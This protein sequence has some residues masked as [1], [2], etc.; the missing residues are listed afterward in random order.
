MTVH[1]FQSAKMPEL[2]GFTVDASGTNLPVED[3][4]W[5]IAGNA[6]PLGTTSR[7]FG[8]RTARHDPRAQTLPRSEADL[9]KMIVDLA[10]GNIE[11][12]APG[13]ERSS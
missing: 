10:A 11:E 7:A 5:E 8:R 13:V 6:I 2:Y 9:A 3:G 12:P 4:P 1:V